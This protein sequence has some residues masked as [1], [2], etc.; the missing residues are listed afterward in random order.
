[1]Q[2][3][4]T[5]GLGLKSMKWSGLDTCLDRSRLMWCDDMSVRW[6]RVDMAR[7]EVGTWQDLSRKA[8]FGAWT[9]I[10][11]CRLCGVWKGSDIGSY[12][13]CETWSHLP[14]LMAARVGTDENNFSSDV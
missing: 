13:T 7:R 11:V 1:M 12:N 10:H 6:L 14:K 2:V 3:K 4:Y 9:R 5:V 8:L